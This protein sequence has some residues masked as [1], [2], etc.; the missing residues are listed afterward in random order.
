M[1][2]AD[3]PALV[4]VV[5]VVV[6]VY[7]TISIIIGLSLVVAV[8]LSVVVV[9]VA[10]LLISCCDADER[11]LLALACVIMTLGRVIKVSLFFGTLLASCFALHSRCHIL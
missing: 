5:V 2:S 1:F 7:I 3:A 11:R 9:A 4:I 10:V 6:V 8:R